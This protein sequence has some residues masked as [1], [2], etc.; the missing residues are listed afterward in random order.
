[1]MLENRSR[2]RMI[3]RYQRP[4][5]CCKATMTSDTTT[6]APNRIFVRQFTSRSNRPILG[7]EYRVQRIG[8]QPTAR[9]ERGSQHV[10]PGPCPVRREIQKVLPLQQWSKNKSYG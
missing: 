9:V 2:K 1:M 8:V 5:K 3:C 4:A 6:S 7:T 10:H